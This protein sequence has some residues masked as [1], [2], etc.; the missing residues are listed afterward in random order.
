[1]NICLL[2]F[3]DKRPV[4]YS[5]L[6]VLG[7]VGRTLLISPNLQFSQ[8]SE[9]YEQDF[10]VMGV[11]II[12]E[13][14][15]FGEILMEIDLEEY[16]YIVFD[17]IVELPEMIDVA[18]IQDNLNYYTDLLEVVD[19]ETYLLFINKA[20]TAEKGNMY[21]MASAAA[22]EKTCMQIE[23]KKLP[24]P[25]TS[26]VHNKMMSALLGKILQMPP[27]SVLKYLKKGV[28]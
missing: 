3:T 15:S 16:N 13:P 10:E 26:S 2:G 6:K 22:L 17:C 7:Q 5:L 25:F 18:L 24:Y 19:E 23:Q 21:M 14:I 8:L 1:M 11:R 12:C 4:I 28:K 20:L 27:Q 9:D